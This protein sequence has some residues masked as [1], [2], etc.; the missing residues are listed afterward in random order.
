MHRWLSKVNEECYTIKQR[1]NSSYIGTARKAVRRVMAPPKLQSPSELE[2]IQHISLFFLQLPLPIQT[3]VLNFLRKKKAIALLVMGKTAYRG[4]FFFLVCLQKWKKSFPCIR[5]I[6]ILQ[7]EILAANHLHNLFCFSSV[8][9][10]IHIYILLCANVGNSKLF[11]AIVWIVNL[12][13]VCST[14]S[15]AVSGTKGK[16]EKLRCNFISQL[17]LIKW[18]LF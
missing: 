5:T 6:C 7:G 12:S 16:M 10:G 18:G 9:K 8:L 1:I 3:L 2:H 13:R 15:E 17:N 11:S 14:C 4:F